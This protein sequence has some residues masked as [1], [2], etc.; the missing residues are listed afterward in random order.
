[1]TDKK[2][3]PAPGGGPATGKPDGVSGSPDP[4]DTGQVHGR[5][6]GG[7]SGGGPYPNPYSDKGSDDQDLS[8]RDSQTAYY[9]GDNPN[10]TAKPPNP[11]EA[12]ERSAQGARPVVQEPHEVE[13]DGRTFEVIEDSGVAAAVASGK[14]GTDAGDEPDQQEPGSG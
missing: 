5:S 7:E 6:L 10:A 12:D 14:L 13:A 11:L 4:G 9:G 2:K 1:M 8:G 3:M